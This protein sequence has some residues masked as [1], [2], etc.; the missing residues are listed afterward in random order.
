M[1]GPGELSFM[2]SAQ[3]QALPDTCDVKRA[4]RASDGAGGTTLTWSTIYSDIPCRI[5]SGTATER[6]GDGSVR[7]MRQTVLTLAHDRTVQQGDRVVS[8]GRTY[9]VDGVLEHSW[10]S[11]R[12]VTLVEIP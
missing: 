4:S 7:V 1:L 10:R 3:A 5:A 11:A 9:E 12:R 2:R 8:G 6:Q